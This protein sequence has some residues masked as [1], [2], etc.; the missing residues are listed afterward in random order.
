M[1]CHMLMRLK[2]LQ[3]GWGFSTIKTVML[4]AGAAIILMSGELCCGVQQAQ[5]AALLSKD[6]LPAPQPVPAQLYEDAPV[7]NWTGLYLG[8]TVGLN[9]GASDFNAPFGSGDDDSTGITG[10]VIGGYNMQLGQFVLGVE[11]D[12]SALTTDEQFT[13]GANT[14][15]SEG[16]W[17]TSIR[18]RAGFLVTP[19]TMLYATGGVAW[20]DLDF[21]LNGP[22]GGTQ[23]DT[24][25]GYQVGGGVEVLFGQRWAGRLEYIYTDLEDKTVLYPAG[26]VKY[27]NDIHTVRAGL[28]MRF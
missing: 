8:G 1:G 19:R 23:S 12:W 9:L 17:L 20:A 28:V 22:G 6:K 27:D 13:V 4:A 3:S 15:T 10:G 21:A 24:L 11:G 2:R 7:R 16:N 5:A 26:A 18:G 25:T 14:A